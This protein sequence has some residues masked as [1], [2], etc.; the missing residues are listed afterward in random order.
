[1]ESFAADT[2]TNSAT[3]IEWDTKEFTTLL[4]LF[5]SIYNQI[6]TREEP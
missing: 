3:M 5:Q 2:L 4:P 6:F 1:M